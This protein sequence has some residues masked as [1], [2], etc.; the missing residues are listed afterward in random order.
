M[1]K[2]IHQNSILWKY[3][4][5]VIIYY[6]MVS[7][8]VHPYYPKNTINPSDFR[9]QIQ[10]LKKIFN[11]I[12]LPEAIERADS[13]DSLKNSLV[14]TIDDGFTEC[15]SVIAPILNDEKVP[16]TFF[17]IEH[18]IDNKNM[19][20]QHQLDYLNQTIFV[21]NQNEIIQKFLHQ[22]GTSSNSPSNFQE[23]SRA[24]KMQDKDKFTK[25]LWD[26]GIE[27]SNS[28][29]LQQ[30]QPYLSNQ[31]IQDLINSGF[32]IGS[33]SATH[34]SC[35]LLNYNDL[36]N[37]IVG[38]CERLGNLFGIGIQYFSY[39]FGR[40]AKWEFEN[41]ILTKSN[42]RCLIG[43][44]PRLFKKNSYPK[45]EA[46]NFERNKSKLLYHLFVN[47]FTFK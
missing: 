5:P 7:E 40:R 45:W 25:I 4:N 22:I 6:H 29:W 30:H 42:I 39:P 35:N 27:Q 34:P 17:L 41:M 14:I 28:E 21:E 1:N 9:E 37:E 44:K 33:H 8:K 23:L 36:E 16:A 32:T 3:Q 18:C 20:W 13:D 11:I 19:M 15:F 43:G 46:Y 38:S 47:S 24:W 26:I 12:S 10:N 31:Q 2:A